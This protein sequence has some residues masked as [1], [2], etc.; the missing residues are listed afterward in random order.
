MNSPNK[1]FYVILPLLSAVLGLLLV[2]GAL[3]LLYPIPYALETNMYYA[4]DEYTGFRHKPY[5]NGSYLNNIPAVANSRGHRDEEVEIPKPDGVYRVL[6]S[7]DSFTAG[8]NVLREEAYAQVLERLLKETASTEV[9]VV[10]SGVGGW[11]PFQYAQY[12][13]HY[14]T[15]FEPDLIVVGLFVGNDI[16]IDRFSVEQTRTAVLGRRI[17]RDAALDPWIKLKVVAYDNSHIARAL[18]RVTPASANFARQD[19]DDL[20]DVFVAIQTGRMDTHLARP[21]AENVLIASQVVGELA[22][23][24]SIADRISAKL[25]VVIFP[26]E[27]QL[28]PTLQTA[29]IPEQE[30]GNYDFDMPQTYLREQ[31][32]AAGIATLD[33]LPAFRSDKRCLYMNDTHWVPEGH[34]FVAEQILNY[35]REQQLVP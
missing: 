35:M 25:V 17:S 1:S 3:A 10:N 12:L 23:M 8:A 31:L 33:L 20:S 24:Q 16:Y 13:E 5:S 18:M 27:N 15:E 32:A 28:N 26:D 11:S 2:E 9:D 21:T 6:V 14:G 30:I 7:G 29:I 34:A 22:R 4:A 19:C